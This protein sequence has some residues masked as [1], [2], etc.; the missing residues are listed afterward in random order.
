MAK[1]LTYNATLVERV[2]LTS[3]L[4]IFKV[5]PDEPI[6]GTDPWFVPGQYL[7]LGL[8][9]E[10]Q[11]H[12]GSVQRPM[13]IASAPEERGA[14]EFYIRYVSHPESDN[15]LTHLL[16]KA[17]ASDRIYLRLRPAGK[18]TLPD[19]VGADDPRLKIF[20]AAGTGLAPFVSI[21]RSHHLRDPGAD[22]GGYVLLHGASYPPELGYREEL[23]GY[24]RHGL[25]YMR[26]VSRPKE[27]PE[28]QGDAGRVE[29]YFLPERL[30][31][32]EQRLGFEPGGLRP[33]WAAIFVCG[34]QGTIGEAI[35]RLI[36]R[37]F[38]PENRKLRR[39][40]EVPEEVPASFFF[41][42]YD[43]TPVIEIDNPE[44]IEPLRA[45]LR[46]ALAGG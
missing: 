46:A 3:A 27:S 6:A 35:T 36:P 8:N 14:I 33:E 37:G 30:A 45:Q 44:V 4:A 42:Q 16:W 15:P 22:L 2:D 21:V 24:A 17:K 28:W 43:K 41:E 34:L 1:P 9:N 32:I 38:V 13:S 40:L 31:E 10:D 19:T 5:Q 39:A 29:A 18:F 20:V 12:L 23:E 11:P 7:T 25:H 26:T